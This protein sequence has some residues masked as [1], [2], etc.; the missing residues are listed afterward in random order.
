MPSRCWE[1]K[2]EHRHALVARRDHTREQ[3]GRPGPR[4]PEHG[5][6]A[7]RRLVEAF[8]HVHARSLVAYRHKANA[9][10]LEL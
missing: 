2:H 9:V 7:A 5:R 1:V 10:R 8:G 3:V 6:D 4:I